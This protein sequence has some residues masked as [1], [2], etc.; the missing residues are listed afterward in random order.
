MSVGVIAKA[1][2]LG[3]VSAL[4]WRGTDV[5]IKRIEGRGK[6]ELAGYFERKS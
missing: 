4:A 6:R 3:V 1:I 2:L 5:I